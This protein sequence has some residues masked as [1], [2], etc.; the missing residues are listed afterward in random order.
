MCT[1]RIFFCLFVIEIESMR[2][3]INKKKAYFTLKGSILYL[4][5][6]FTYVALRHPLLKL[7]IA[8]FFFTR[9][10]LKYSFTD[11]SRKKKKR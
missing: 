10:I 1:M 5:P 11:I 4:H 2:K 7:N 8:S 3:S 6:L 9:L